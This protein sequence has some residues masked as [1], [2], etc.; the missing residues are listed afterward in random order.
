MLPLLR[1]NRELCCHPRLLNRL[2]E[3]GCY[4]VIFLL[5]YM[6]VQ[7]TGGEIIF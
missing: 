6:T 2:A 1:S 4:N 5:T 3:F 7:L